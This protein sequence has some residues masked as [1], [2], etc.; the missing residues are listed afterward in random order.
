LSIVCVRSRQR[1]PSRAKRR[2]A[3]AGPY[4]NVV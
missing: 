3:A 4:C 2:R 1:L